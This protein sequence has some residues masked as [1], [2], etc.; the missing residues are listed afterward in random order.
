MRYFQNIEVA[1]VLDEIANLL[2][3]KGEQYYKIRAY[4]RAAK[5]IENMSDDINELYKEKR[6]SEVSGVGKNIAAKLEELLSTGRVTYLEKLKKEIPAGVVEIM[7]I[8][9]LGPKMAKNLSA[10]LGIETLEQLEE[11]A[12]GKKIRSLPGMGSKTEMNI[13]RGIEMLKSGGGHATLGIAWAVADSFVAFLESLPVV[14]KVA[15]GGSTRRMKEYIRDLDIVVSTENPAKVAEV[16]VK[17]P[18]V[19]EVLAQGDTKVSVLLRFGIQVDI[20]VVA[21]DEF[22]TALHHFTGSKEHNVRL[23]ERSRKYGIKINEYGLFREETGERIGVTS[24][25][26]IYS[27]L[28]LPYIPPELREDQGEFR[29]AEEHRL[30]KL[31]GYNDIKG[32]LHLHSDWSDGVN[33]I[34]EIVKQAEKLGYEYV[35]I[36]DHSKS[37]GIARG[38]SVERLAEQDKAIKSFLEQGG[39]VKILRGIEADILSNGDMDYPDEILAQK[40]IVIGSIHSRFRQDKEKLTSRIISAIKNEHVDIIAHPTG[41][42]IGRR[43]P[44][45]I[46]IERVF[47]AAV[48][49]NKVLEINSSPDRLDLKDTYVRRAKEMGIKIAINTDAHEIQRMHEIKF[50]VGTARRGWLERADVINAM[51]Y[52]E[53]M[54]YLGS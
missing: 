39:P 50:G 47:E 38:L 3:I 28:E 2:E 17:H 12:R 20:R 49:Y 41:R 22:V 14:G 23:R 44:Y 36:T 18:Q 43:D 25:E 11:A 53:L 31:I 46:D 34:E 45:D 24:E 1:W 9:G 29:A 48:K 4:R 40:D 26:D 35:A 8:P 15:V 5:V 42:L 19:K 32:D 37:L 7:S 10:K 52:D 51:S 21:P 13:L 6:L 30:P 16:F 54:D 33:S 27:R